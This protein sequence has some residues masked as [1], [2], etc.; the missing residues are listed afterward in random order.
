MNRARAALVS[1]ALTSACGGGG[2]RSAAPVT[3]AARPSA[4]LTTPLDRSRWLPASLGRAPSLERLPDGTRRGTVGRV[5]VEERPDG[6]LRAARELLPSTRPST[7]LSLPERLGGGYVFAS[8]G[9]PSLVHHAPSFLGPLK[10]IARAQ[11]SPVT[12][13]PARDRLLIATRERVDAVELTTGRAVAPASLPPYTRFAGGAYAAPDRALYLLDLWGLVETHDGGQTFSRVDLPGAR[14]VALEDGQLLAVTPLARFS[15]DANGE[16]SLEGPLSASAAPARPLPPPM[17]G[18]PPLLAAV[19]GGWPV[20]EDALV[21]ARRGWVAVVGAADGEVLARSRAMP[22]EEDSDCLAI[23]FGVDVGFVCGGEGRGTRVY[24]FV[25]P[26][27]AR[28]A[29]SWST[30]RI[31]APSGNGGLVVHGGCADGPSQRGL[32]CVISPGGAARDVRITG[33]VGAS[34]VIALA[35]GAAAVLVPPRGADDGSLTVVA[36]SGSMKRAPLSLPERPALRRGLW[37]EGVQ[38]A[39]DGELTAWVEAG[40]SMTGVRVSKN[41]DV[42]AGA[43]RT[44]PFVSVSGLVGAALSPSSGRAFET[45]DGGLTWDAIAL[46]DAGQGALAGP[47]LR[48]GQAGCVVSFEQPWLR[49]GWGAPRD[50]GELAPPEETS[51]PP[52]RSFLRR[53][54]ALSCELVSVEAPPTRSPLRGDA[55]LPE[56]LGVAPP[57]VPEGSRWVS[58]PVLGAMG[59]R[60]YA[61]APR[62]AKGGGTRF[63]AR[64]VDRFASDRP[65]RSTAVTRAPFADEAALVDALGRDG[66]GLIVHG[67]PDPGG[68]GVLLSACRSGREDCDLYGAADGRSLTRLPV[69][70]ELGLGRAIPPSASAVLL[71]DTW[72]LALSHA[73]EAVVVRLEPEGAR[74]LARLPRH[75]SPPLVRLTRPA[76][77]RGLG[78]LVR[79][80]GTF[81]KSDEDFLLFPIDPDSGARAAPLR[82]VSADLG[83]Q[84]PP[85][86]TDDDD[87]W[88]AEVPFGYAP[89]LTGAQIGDVELRARLDV[90]VACTDALAGRL[91]AAP[92]SPRATVKAVGWP[93]VALGPGGARV[94]ASCR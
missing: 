44:E 58:E 93:M 23:R 69:A 86:C 78:L 56:F 28:L 33:D 18:A 50:P 73:N 71:D 65:V 16:T 6:S 75:G 40:G 36:P 94:T 15:V 7:A 13:V 11:S 92:T 3:P 5:R 39:G 27:S 66:P 60:L 22:D 8:P 34:R 90:G 21:V 46:P 35:D 38:E 1:L 68:A 4:A 77:A 79:G 9:S 57:E 30:P 49:V 43:S 64:Y 19:E 20:S 61:W 10:L 76:R 70:E 12:L 51:L 17:L 85:L 37:L 31:V 87:G 74:V 84:A 48:C 67:L 29:W 42:R 59:A 55:H 32:V 24:A 53:P 80:Q 63:V 45:R 82:L 62:G 25:P 2:S 91:R 83:G 52:R 26:S 14:G 54:R 47:G 81:D 72:F 88:L 89:R 41:G